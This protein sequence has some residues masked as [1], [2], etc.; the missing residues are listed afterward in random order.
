MCKTTSRTCG[1]QVWWK[2]MACLTYTSRINLCCKQLNSFFPLLSTVSHPELLNSEQLWI[3]GDQIEKGTSQMGEQSLDA[4]FDHYSESNLCAGSY[5]QYPSEINSLDSDKGH[6]Q[7]DSS[8]QPDSGICVI[9]L[10][11]GEYQHASEDK[12]DWKTHAPL[13]SKALGSKRKNPFKGSLPRLGFK[14]KKSTQLSANKNPTGPHCCKACGKSFHYMYTLRT[15]AQAHAVDNKHICGICG[16][17]LKPTENLIEHLQSHKKRNKC[18]V[19]GKQFSNDAR[20]KRHMTFHR[21]KGINF[22]EISF[23]I[24]DG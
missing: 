17:Y 21:P 14:I 19:C 4:G 24:T 7:S 6:P 8:T 2:S 23:N 9:S 1:N 15:H 3:K 22:N 16:K 10:L 18:G 11:A 13:S 5:I 20:L 12:M